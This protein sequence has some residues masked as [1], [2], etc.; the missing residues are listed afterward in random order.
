MIIPARE[1]LVAKEMDRLVLD[2]GNALLGLDMLKAVCF[3]PAGWENIERDLATDGEPKLILV[4]NVYSSYLLQQ[5]SKK[6][7]VRP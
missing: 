2:S 3:V 5:K 4:R 1:R 6:T 7:Y